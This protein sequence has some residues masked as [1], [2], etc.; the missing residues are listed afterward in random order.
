VRFA[1]LSLAVVVVLA[2]AV[3]SACS[4]HHAAAPV[5]DAALPP[6][7]STPPAL[8]APAAQVDAT[9]SPVVFDTLRGGVWTANGDVGTVSYADI[10]AFK[11]DVEIPIG[12]DVRSVAESPDKVWIA[13]VD[14]AGGTV[15]LVNGYTSVVARTI[16]V[17]THPRAAVWNAS[18][19]RWLYVA[20]EGDDAVAIVDRTLGVLAQTIPVGRM[21]AG[22]AVSR[23]RNELYVTHRIDAKI[24]IVDLAAG[25]LVDDVALAVQPAQ[26]DPT[27]PQGK[28]FAFE[29]LAWQ[30]SPDMTLHDQGGDLV[31]VPHELFAPTHPFQF[32]T[33][34]FPAISVVDLGQRGEVAGARKLLFDD[35]DIPDPEGNTSV[36]SQPCA[37]AQHPNAIAVYALACGSDDLLT[38]DATQGI[39]VGLRRDL[40]GDHPVGLTLDDTGRRLFVVSDQSHTLLAYDTAYGS[41]VTQLRLIN[42]TPLPLVA[43]DPLDPQLR[44]GQTLFFSANGLAR[45]AYATTGNN[46]LSCGA[47]HLDGFGSGEEALFEDSHLKDPTRDAQIGH[48]GLVDLFSTASKPTA[49][50]FN[51]HDILVALLEQGGM[52]PD[53]TGAN[54]AGAVDPSHPPAAAVAMATQLA[55]VVARDLPAGPS[56]MSSTGPPNVG[57]DTAYCGQCHSR[58]YAAWQ[59]SAHAHSGADP[60]M[61]YCAGVETGLAGPAFQGLC[62]GC[63]DPIGARTG[64]MTLTSGRGVTCLGCHEADYP[65]RAGGNAGL[66]ETPYDWTVSH[67]ERAQAQLATL[68]QP[69]FCG[70]CHSQF[71]PGTGLIGIDTLSAWKASRFAGAS[72]T[73]PDGGLADEDAGTIPSDDAAMDAEPDAGPDAPPAASA[74]GGDAGVPLRD[75]PPLDAGLTDA[76]SGVT[77]CVDCHMP[78]TNGL[79]DHRFLGGNVYLASALGDGTTVA[80]LEANLAKA[81][82][83]RAARS[84]TGYLVQVTNVG[85]GHAFPNGVPDIRE[86]WVEVDALDANKNVLARFGGPDANNLIP[87]SAARLGLDFAGADGGVLLHHELSVATAI[88]FDRR[89][90]PG[91]TIDLFVPGPSA[92]PPGT[93]EV[94]AILYYRNVRTPFYRA[95]SGVGTGAAPDVQVARVVVP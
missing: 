82:K 55:Y 32:Q 59:Q 8:V 14:R 52:A 46:W 71:V 86:P 72:P 2:V 94:D 36:V 21:P 33:T 79:A 85:A 53:R 19:P 12:K 83:L 11:V 3:A 30:P 61:L 38:F 51:P 49:P 44:A 15:A 37:I 91:M 76:D 24:S 60:M 31:W 20:L 1:T 34:V 4:G 87:A 78:V 95:A 6:L 54:L 57:N 89:I 45:G 35:I 84:G 23:K 90:P 13:A 92:L 64:D 63:H 66:V 93:A 22:L 48:S 80:A 67:K 81:V 7:E 41:V 65:I 39:A 68:R 10:D 42:A 58:E 77:R 40:A 88:P 70:S 73:F 17:G 47:C 25:V 56:W 43:K 75:P 62:V 16:A 50:G 26:S 69:E 74:D 29:G 5:A 18:D 9:S 27:V 28:P